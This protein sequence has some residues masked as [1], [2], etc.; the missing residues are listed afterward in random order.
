VPLS[1]PSPPTFARIDLRSVIH[2]L[3]QT[4]RCLL[5]TCDILAVVKANAY[6]HGA[7]PVARALTGAG[8]RHL[9]VAT[10][11]EGAQL[12]EAGIDHPIVVLGPLVTAEMPALVAHRLTPVIYDLRI[13]RDLAKQMP[14]TAKPYPIHVKIDTGMGRLGLNPDEWPA[15]LETTGLDRRL[16]LEGLMT[17]LADADSAD[18]AYT[19]RQLERFDAALSHV[20]ASGHKP[21]LVHMA[22]SAGII[23]YPAS[24]YSLVRPGI[25]LY[26]YH[27]LPCAR[28]ALDLR[29]A[30]AWHTTIATIRSIPRGGCVGYN[31]TFTALRA[32]R[33]AVLPVGYADGYS[34]RLSNTGTVLI[35][36]R[37]M[38]V[39]GRVSM[40]MT[41]VDVTDLPEA[42]PGDPVV[43]LGRQGS[44]SIIATDI[45][46]TLDTIP[47]EV[48]C[49]IGPRVPR[50]YSEDSEASAS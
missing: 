39:V 41:M 44:A 13:V 6:G 24:H 48:L 34:R 31:R 42:K 14:P 46:A 1:S 5:G 29:P 7:V 3:N 11:D 12:R 28:P 27:T 26:G 20:A 47:Y 17:H 9:G 49:S 21:P 50:L 25:M 30:L 15:L 19:N 4:R 8:V 23:M 43:L 36:G 2:N 40:D 32:S 38:P 16:S 35:G 45:A 37:R 10:M 18:S 33:I 22:N